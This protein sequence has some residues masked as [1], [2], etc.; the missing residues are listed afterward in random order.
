[1]K[2]LYVFCMLFS[3]H[4]TVILG[5]VKNDYTWLMGYST[6][7][8]DMPN[9]DE[10]GGVNFDFSTGKPE[11]STFDI[12]ATGV[13]GVANDINGNL[14][15]YTSGCQIFNKKHKVMEGGDDINIGGS[16]VGWRCADVYPALNN[17]LSSTIMLPI[18]ESTTRYLS[19]QMRLGEDS[20][21]YFTLGKVIN[22]KQVVL[23]DSLHDNAKVVR[24]GNGRDWWIVVPRGTEREFWVIPVTPDGVGEPILRTQ[25]KQKIFT[26][27][28]EQGDPPNN[29]EAVN[30]Y[31]FESFSGQANFSPDGNRFCR[32][33]PYNGV[34]IFDFDRCAGDLT[35]RKTIPMPPDSIYIKVNREIQFC[36]L[37]ISPNNRF[38]YF[39][40]RYGLFQY[41]MCNENLD[42]D[43]LEL[44]DYYDLYKEDD[45]FVTDFFLMQNGPDG[46][47]YMTATNSVRS[48]HV[49]NEPNQ[50]G[51]ACNFVQR[52]IKLPRWTYVTINY[53]PNFRLYDLANSPCDTLNINDPNPPPKEEIS[54][55]VL[56]VYPNPANDLLKIY[57]PQC[58]G[59]KIV[60]WN[61]T[62]QK[63][64][65]I[66][67]LPGETV[68]EISTTHWVSGTYIIMIYVDDKKP[69]IF[70]EMVVH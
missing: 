17:L 51:K 46:K 2:N 39:T 40:N 43:R 32:I 7:I 31:R 6:L 11:I 35:L 13:N 16:Q 70:K 42:K 52:G 9:T 14:Q 56:K 15:F 24:H 59:A 3:I 19:F 44:I 30:E 68:N 38:L 55:D 41:D 27:I 29:F 50:F 12:Y 65:E 1:M 37:A 49:I 22:K 69:E 4:T 61:M 64:E 47:I 57:V 36:G 62:G 18:P 21:G 33:V 54:F 45:Y 26:Y 66:P 67:Y 58:N 8:P 23:S 25:P 20:I 10:F 28:I 48:L 63:Q 60:I 5:Q 53:F 34:E